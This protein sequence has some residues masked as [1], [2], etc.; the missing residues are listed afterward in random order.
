VSQRPSYTPAAWGIPQ[1][2]AS[3]P[4]STCAEWCRWGAV[5]PR[6]GLSRRDKEA[7]L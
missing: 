3:L 1:T 5:W 7:D 2:A 6:C 4:F